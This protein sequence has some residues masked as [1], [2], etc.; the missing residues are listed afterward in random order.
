MRRPTAH[1]PP[2]AERHRIRAAPRIRA[3]RRLVRRRRQLRSRRRPTAP[4]RLSMC[5]RRD[6]ADHPRSALRSPPAL[7]GALRA[8]AWPQ[9][10]RFPS[11]WEAAAAGELS[12]PWPALARSRRQDRSRQAAGWTSA[13]FSEGEG[14]LPETGGEG[15]GSVGIAPLY[16]AIAG[17][18]NLLD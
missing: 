15:G 13:H 4:A 9:L 1:R 18:A 7:P 12:A 5:S 16:K 10:R 3:P 11:L 14:L 2:R 8:T 17:V 6:C